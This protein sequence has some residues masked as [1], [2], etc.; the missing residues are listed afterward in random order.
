MPRLVCRACGKRLYSAA[1]LES[2]FADERRCPRCASPLSSDRRQLDRRQV[3]RRENPAD[4]PGPPGGDER[5][6]DERRKGRRRGS[7]H[8]PYQGD[9]TGW[10]E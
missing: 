5:R 10:I 1:P 4:E 2:L 6:V 9:D 3:Q 8:G 7:D